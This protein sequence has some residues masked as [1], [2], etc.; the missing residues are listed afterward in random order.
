MFAKF[1]AEK[2]S[3]T[4]FQGIMKEQKIL[5][6]AKLIAEKGSSDYCHA[7][8]KRRAR[9]WKKLNLLNFYNKPIN[10]PQFF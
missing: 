7:I 10:L 4:E 3:S 2:I 6:F 8:E 5:R 9:E 1:K